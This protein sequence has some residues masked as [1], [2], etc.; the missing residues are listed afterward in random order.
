V[1]HRLKFVKITPTHQVAGVGFAGNLFIILSALVHVGD[2]EKMY[3]DMTHDCICSEKDVFLHNTHNSWEYY[4]DQVKLKDGEKINEMNSLIRGNLSYE[5]R[6]M[7]MHPKNF[8]PL[9]EKFYRNFQLKP[10]LKKLIDDYYNENI[11]G[12]ITLGVQVRLTDMKH[13]HN[14][15]SIEKYI[16]K[17]NEILISR[18][19]IEQIFLATDDNLV[20]EQLRAVINIP[21]LCYEGMFRADS[22]NRHTDPHAR[23]HDTR[24][25]HRY[26]LGIECTKDIMTLSKCDYLLK[27][28]L[29][30]ISIVASILSENIKQVYKV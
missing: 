21:I 22:N 8:I 16:S 30:S 10:Y 14:V 7:F 12:K 9:K 5:N 18:Q 25:L 24:E 28:D 27:A 3:V 23:L 29:S 13:H 6:D 26:N 2:D 4:F 20:I 19:E 17:I 15:S 11:K 1:N